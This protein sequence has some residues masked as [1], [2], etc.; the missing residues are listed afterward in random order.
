VRRWSALALV[1]A[2]L[3][4]ASPA[5]AAFLTLSPEEIARA[6]AVGQKSVTS[7][8]AFD[9]EWTVTNDAGDRLTVMTPFHRLVL[10]ARHA[11]FKGEPLKPN[12]PERVL[13]E[14]K[15]RLPL[16]VQLRGPR[17]DFARHY[18]PRLVLLGGGER[19][20]EPSFVQ[21]ERSAVRQ[22]DRFVARCVYG[23]SLRDLTPTSRVVLVVRDVE[24]RDVSRFTIDLSAMR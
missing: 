23:F 14:Q 16:W 8:R 4:P 20:I 15:D 5:A 17:E 12:E 10:A 21:N 7:D 13:K 22:G 2:L 6:L 1:I 18:T 9:A 11:T 3:G 24:Q 19:A